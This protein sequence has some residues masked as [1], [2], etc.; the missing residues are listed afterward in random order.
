MRT[1]KYESSEARYARIDREARRI[2]EEQRKTREDKTSRLRTLRL[3]RE[4]R[5]AA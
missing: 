5:E 4:A 3:A 1:A 2:I